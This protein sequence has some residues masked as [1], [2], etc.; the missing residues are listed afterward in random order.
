M[1]V[2]VSSVCFQFCCHHFKS[3]FGILLFPQM[4]DLMLFICF[5]Q[6]KKSS[7]AQ[8]VYPKEMEVIFQVKKADKNA[9]T[10]KPKIGTTL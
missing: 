6:V 4:F 8:L 2:N 7:T 3:H 10:L 9:F 5:A 1:S